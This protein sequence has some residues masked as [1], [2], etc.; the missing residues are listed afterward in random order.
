MF[1]TQYGSDVIV[2]LLKQYKITYVTGNPGATIRGLYDSIIHDDS[3]NALQ[4][5]PCC[6][7]EIAV[8][9]AHGYAK[10]A[11]KPMAVLLHANIGLLHAS[12]A[13]FNAW[14]DRVP[15]LILNGI[16]PMAAD[17][18]RLWIDWIHTSSSPGHCVEG[19]TKWQDEPRNLNSAVESIQ[20][21]MSQTLQKPQAPVLISID[22]GIQ[23]KKLLP[24]DKTMLEK[25]KPTLSFASTITDEDINH[26]AK[27]IQSAK[28]PCVITGTLGR[29]KKAVHLLIA[30][31][32]RLG[33]AVIDCGSALNFPNQHSL[34]LTEMLDAEMQTVDCVIA[35]DVINL[36]SEIG[37]IEE[38]KFKHNLHPSC[39]IIQIG[40][41]NYLLSSEVADYHRFVHADFSMMVDS[42]E[43]LKKLNNFFEVHYTHHDEQ[44]A[45]KRFK[46]W[47]KIHDT[48]QATWKHEVNT[49]LGHAL[50]SPA[51]VIKKMG[52]RLESEKFVLVNGASV[53]TQRLTRR[54]W[55][56]NEDNI[57]LGHSGGAGLGYGMG[58]SI[59][60]ALVFKNTDRLLINLQSDGDLLFTPSA[61][62]T[63]AH[64][65]LPLLTIVMNN[66]GYEN[67]HQ[68]AYRIATERHR[69]KTQCDAGQLFESP[70]VDFIGLAKSFGI[71][72]WPRITALPQMQKILD[73]AIQ[74]I[75]K[76]KK[77]VVLE[78]IIQQVGTAK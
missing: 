63:L 10:A 72:T 11:N 62:W 77:P 44:K 71:K 36:A 29:N 78:I 23:E 67:T 41:D 30:L 12:M 68:H 14:C 59:G 51:E 45:K 1:N 37:Y 35:L 64:C 48:L 39:K 26:V 6:H 42:D 9:I 49:Q 27:I 32:E 18:R 4:L 55:N 70:A 74:F 40:L 53:A 13:I 66:Q 75:Q 34:C 28:N 20:R 60:A 73:Q 8:A 7:E 46:K 57:T 76:E 56:F 19:F 31:A 24:S 22:S 2:S 65:E 16:G 43:I 25:L 38:G 47:S 5:I 3:E 17:Q 58:A 21:A 50:L 15:M 61:L 54:F 69:I 33:L 52:E